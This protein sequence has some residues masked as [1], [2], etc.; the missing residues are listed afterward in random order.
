MQTSSLVKINIQKRVSGE[1]TNRD[2]NERIAE[3]G[4]KELEVLSQDMSREDKNEWLPRLKEVIEPVKDTSEDEVGDL[5]RQQID[6]SVVNELKDDPSRLQTIC[7]PTDSRNIPPGQ[8]NGTKDVGDTPQE[9]DNQKT[10]NVRE[11]SQ[12]LV[13][14]EDEHGFKG[15]YWC[16]GPT[17]KSS[18]QHNKGRSNPAK[19][20]ATFW[21]LVTNTAKR[22]REQND[23]GFRGGGTSKRIKGLAIN[24][25]GAAA[26]KINR[27]QRVARSQ[28]GKR[29]R[30][31]TSQPAYSMSRIYATC[32]RTFKED[33]WL[34]N[35]TKEKQSNHF[36][37]TILDNEL[38][39]AMET[40]I[41]RITPHNG[42]IAFSYPVV[43]DGT[44]VQALIS[45]D[46]AYWMLDAKMIQSSGQAASLLGETLS[47]N[48]SSVTFDIQYG[49]NY[50]TVKAWLETT[51][52]G[53]IRLGKKDLWELGISTPTPEIERAFK[54]KGNAVK[55]TPQ[56]AQPCNPAAIETM[57]KEHL[58]A[59]SPARSTLP[60]LKLYDG[61][62]KATKEPVQNRP[63]MLD[64]DDFNS[65]E[66][67]S[68]NQVDTKLLIPLLRGWQREVVY[69]RNK[70]KCDIYYAAP[71]PEKS[72]RAL[73][74]SQRKKRSLKDI[75]RH[76]AKYPDNALNIDNFSYE[77]KPLG[78]LCDLYKT[79]RNANEGRTFS[80]DEFGYCPI[81]TGFARGQ[82]PIIN[83]TKRADGLML[84]DHKILTPQ[85]GAER[86]LHEASTGAWDV[87]INTGTITHADP[88]H[89]TK[90]EVDASGKESDS[91]DEDDVLDEE[92]I[93]ESLKQEYLSEEDGTE[94]FTEV[95]LHH[96]NPE[97]AMQHADRRHTGAEESD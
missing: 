76:L 74:R 85:A 15:M 39:S 79:V 88:L 69:R 94:N 89:I 48:S 38:E 22:N 60:N 64:N 53:Q 18:V 20:T 84:W 62:T 17:P 95:H 65:E 81:H 71:Q 45:A 5:L 16:R 42:A 57:Q 43:I 14:T 23:Y 8:K 47:R 7:Y 44:V 73:N 67:D 83:I 51:R 29:N 50:T 1:T 33:G 21:L 49:G 80:S 75:M 82:C 66:D 4:Q 37:T 13:V 61:I 3:A 97:R 59:E 70:N 91:G 9:K 30:R 41:V 55:T 6:Q 11:L 77:K 87:D 72:T 32:E 56:Y 93:L 92:D 78:I 96:S 25:A 36:H 24:E 27:D 2:G 52:N 68:P 63:E 46:L 40:R 54:E 58:R 12:P 28:P 31:V 90:Q 34:E 10:G 86:G 35:E 26:R 19:Y